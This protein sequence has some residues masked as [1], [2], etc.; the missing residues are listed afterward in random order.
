MRSV[1]APFFL[2]VIAISGV[3]LYTGEICPRYAP[4]SFSNVDS[5]ASPHGVSNNT[6]IFTKI[7][8]GPGELHEVIYSF[9]NMFYGDS[10]SR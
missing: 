8:G 2:L 5:L 1:A 9:I 10:S 6:T 4:K 3:I 7:R